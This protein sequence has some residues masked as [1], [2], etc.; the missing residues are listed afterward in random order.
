MSKVRA[1]SIR[2]LFLDYLFSL[3][4]EETEIKK[5][6]RKVLKNNPNQNQT[7]LEVITKDILRGKREKK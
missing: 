5:V 6:W 4:F 1:T 3:G 2:G 7:T